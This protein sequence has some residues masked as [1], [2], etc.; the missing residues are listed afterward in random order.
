MVEVFFSGSQDMGKEHRLGPRASM[1]HRNAE[2]ILSSNCNWDQL[3]SSAGRIWA[4]VG[5]GSP[6]TPLN[7]DLC[8]RSGRIL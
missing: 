2:S 6:R 4:L 3:E 1:G 5:P 7:Q 8:N